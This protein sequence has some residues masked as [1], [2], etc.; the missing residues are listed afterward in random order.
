MTLELPAAALALLDT[1][2]GA[3]AAELRATPA[4]LLTT[5]QA[6]GYAVHAAV[7]AFEASYGGLVIPEARGQAPDDPRWLF[8][9]HACLSSEAHVAPRGGD[10]ARRLVPVIYSPNDVIYF[11]D[12]NGRG[13]AQDTIEERAAVLYAA[14]GRAL[15]TRVLLHNALFTLQQSSLELPRLEGTR[16]AQHFGLALIAE[17]SGQDLRFY[18][19]AHGTTIV[20]EV[21]D[22]EQTVLASSEVLDVSAFV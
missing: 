14:D 9:A 3:V 15:V 13:Y 22:N 1:N 5:C 8:G 19:D 7:A 12:G 21:L 20:C 4:Q 16:L 17:A 6:R 11:L 2:G 10:V 18:G